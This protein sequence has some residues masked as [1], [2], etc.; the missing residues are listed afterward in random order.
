MK[1]LGNVNQPRVIVFPVPI[2]LPIFGKGTT[3]L[4]EKILTWQYYELHWQYRPFKIIFLSPLYT[5]IIAPWWID[6]MDVNI[7]LAPQS[8][9]QPNG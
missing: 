4:V 9:Y 7:F 2:I 3:L 1:L 5:S 8:V 6:V